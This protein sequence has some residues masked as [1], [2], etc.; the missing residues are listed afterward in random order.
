LAIGGTKVSKKLL[1]KI[2]KNKKIIRSNE[3][4][5]NTLKITETTI[6]DNKCKNS[7]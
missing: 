1:G 6:H 3:I 4:D 2:Q 5:V 7:I